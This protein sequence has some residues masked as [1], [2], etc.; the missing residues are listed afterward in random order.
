MGQILHGI[1]FG[2]SV[3]IGLAGAGGIFLLI[4]LF[5]VVNGH[6][7]VQSMET[8]P[9]IVHCLGICNFVDLA[10]GFIGVVMPIAIGI[11]RPVHHL[12]RVSRAGFLKSVH[13][14]V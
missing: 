12:G 1:G 7:N 3:D 9:A 8:K 14:V 5:Q 6:L 4:N 2:H 10:A 13:L 11:P